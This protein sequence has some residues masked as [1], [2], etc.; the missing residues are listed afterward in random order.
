MKSRAHLGLEKGVLKLV[1]AL[2][3]EGC[4]KPVGS[5]NV[6]SLGVGKAAA[7]ERVLVEK[8]SLFP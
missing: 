1:A 6:P 2:D 8:V 5:A 4:L 3:S 7:A